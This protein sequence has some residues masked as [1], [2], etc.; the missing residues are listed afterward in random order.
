VDRRITALVGRAVAV[1]RLSEQVARTACSALNSGDTSVRRPAGQQAHNDVHPPA[2]RLDFR[3]PAE[4][5]RGSATRGLRRRD[6]A[7]RS[8]AQLTS[9]RPGT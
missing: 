9:M 2:R 6:Q 7:G 1:Q 8:T 5:W 4:R 3:R